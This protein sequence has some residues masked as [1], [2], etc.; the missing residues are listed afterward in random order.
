MDEVN[1]INTVGRQ[2]FDSEEKETDRTA[3]DVGSRDEG[4]LWKLCHE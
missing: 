2:G 1:E 3:V 4:V